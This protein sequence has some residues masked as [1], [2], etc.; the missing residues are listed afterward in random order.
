MPPSLGSMLRVQR[1]VA[2]RSALPLRNK[3]PVA[4][5]RALP[6]ASGGLAIQ[7]LAALDLL[8]KKAL[9]MAL[10]PKATPGAK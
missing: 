6:L 4:C 3:R 8:A 10:L 9:T 5:R 7:H 1:P 2:C